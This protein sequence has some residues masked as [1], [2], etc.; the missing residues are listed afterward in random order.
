MVTVRY[1]DIVERDAPSRAAALDAVGAVA[2]SGSF[3]GGASLTEFETALAR[4]HR[5]G[6]AVGVASGTDALM[7]AL[8]AVGVGVDTEVIVP[9]VSFFATAGAVLALG[10]R[11]VVV[12]VLPDSPL[13]DP[14]A[15]RRVQGVRSVLD[16]RVVSTRRGGQGPRRDRGEVGQERCQRGAG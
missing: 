13:M 9:A 11:P 3:V 7:L 15:A 12:D 4:V 6:W 5:V 8:Q 2:A 10:A 1:T 16:D 14:D